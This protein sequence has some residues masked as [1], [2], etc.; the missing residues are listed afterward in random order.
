MAN[1]GDEW[2]LMQL[3][4]KVREPIG[5]VGFVDSGKVG[6]QDRRNLFF[7]EGVKL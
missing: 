3:A 5:R 2:T 4:S 6:E 7:F 1:H